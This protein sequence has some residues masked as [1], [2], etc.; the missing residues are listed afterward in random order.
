[1]HSFIFFSIIS[2]IKTI[3]PNNMKKV[4]GSDSHPPVFLAIVSEWCVHCHKMK[5]EWDKLKQK[6]ENDT[7][8]II[9]TID[10]DA[11]RNIVSYFPQYNGT[12][13]LFWV[14]KT[15]DV[16]EL[17]HGKKTY[18]DFEQY[19][20]QQLASP[21]YEINNHSELTN[22]LNEHIN[23][24]V[25]IL[26]GSPSSEILNIIDDSLFW[27][28]KY[29][30]KFLHINFI[31]FPQEKPNS[32]SNQLILAYINTKASSQLFYNGD[33]TNKTLFPFIYQHKLPTVTT[34]D[35]AFFNLYLKE[36]PVDHFV[37]FQDSETNSYLDN[38]TNLSRNYPNLNFGCIIC[39]KN[40]V[41]CKEYGMKYHS[42]KQLCV[43]EPKWRRYY[44]FNGEY[45]DENIKN[46]LDKA[47]KR[48]LN[49]S[50]PG[51][52]WKGIFCRINYILQNRIIFY[53]VVFTVFASI[54]I[55]VLIYQA[56][57]DSKYDKDE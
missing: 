42:N 10:Y 29:P 41:R 51:A 1:M 23:D 28:K 6:Y 34:A 44:L 49:A 47:L 17:Y 40:Y 3:T 43:I 19:I 56:K 33:W 25:F 31:E 54:S 20:K 21:I 22:Y 46:F 52:G 24:Q 14:K 36:D 9:G 5:P 35:E 37:L 27:V 8:I 13:A 15:P 32:D 30:V 53:I 26:Q 11:H 2:L 16:S 50:G 48:K 57:M 45:N 39:R 12:P 38:L 55:P 4:I 7:N 18:E